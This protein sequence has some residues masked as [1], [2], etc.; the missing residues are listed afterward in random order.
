MEGKHNSEDVPGAI[1]GQSALRE[2]D[3]GCNVVERR[4]DIVLQPLAGGYPKHVCHHIH[5][6]EQIDVI[7]GTGATPAHSMSSGS[8]SARSLA[9]VPSFGQGQMTSQG[10]AFSSLANADHS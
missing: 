7:A 4:C 10:R 1:G 2:R 9:V 5:V 8:K 6:P 3:A